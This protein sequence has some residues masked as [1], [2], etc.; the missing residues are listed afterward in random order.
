MAAEQVMSVR[1]MKFSKLCPGLNL[2]TMCHRS[3]EYTAQKEQFD[4][5][6]QRQNRVLA[7]LNPELLM[8]KLARAGQ[9]AE[10]DA[11]AQYNT[12]VEGTLPLD[13]FITD[14]SKKKA[15]AHSRNLKS[16]AAAQ[17]LR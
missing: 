10:N 16:S 1:Y 2:V 8:G 15:L 9:D 13:R 11:E 14:Y 3:S 4:D 7:K 5:V 6:V 12:F 17:T